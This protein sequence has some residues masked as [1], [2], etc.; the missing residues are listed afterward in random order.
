MSIN[1]I[2]SGNRQV[3]FENE[4]RAVKT[5]GNELPDYSFLL[6]PKFTRLFKMIYT[7]TAKA[8]IIYTTS[9]N[10]FFPNRYILFWNKCEISTMIYHFDILF[11]IQKTHFFS[12]FLIKQITVLNVK[13]LS[14]K[15]KSYDI[16]QN[17]IKTLNSILLRLEVLQNKD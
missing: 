17:S 6:N 8:L 15:S 3:E 10:A 1:Y 16:V 11:K 12:I 2:Q 14:N 9:K 7:L 13:T 5:S 4:D